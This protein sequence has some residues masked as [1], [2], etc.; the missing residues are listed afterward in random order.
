ML[1][2]RLQRIGK[3]HQ[4][5]FRIVV[6][7]RRS[8]LGGPPVEDLG[9]YNPQTKAMAVDKEKVAH[10][11]KVGAKATP[12]VHNLLVKAGAIVG[13]KVAIKI[14]KPK[15][16]AEASAA[17]A[18]STEPAVTVAAVEEEKPKEET[19]K[20]EVKTEPEAAA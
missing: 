4:P 1:V 11:I 7:E 12:T 19:P 8:K 14:K 9:A 6:S 18:V 20:A 5:S 2:I 17:P 13:P 3:K 16:V 10:W 15:A